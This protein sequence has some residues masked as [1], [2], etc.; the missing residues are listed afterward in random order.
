MKAV[1]NRQKCKKAKEQTTILLLLQ[2][3]T[4]LPSFAHYLSLLNDAVLL[5]LEQKAR[6]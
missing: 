4:I 2:L 3:M 1:P 6:K 5:L